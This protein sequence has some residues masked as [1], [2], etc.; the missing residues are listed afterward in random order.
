MN[1]FLT[2]L[3]ISLTLTRLE[4]INCPEFRHNTGWLSKEC[5][6]SSYCQYNQ[7][8]AFDSTGVPSTRNDISCGIPGSQAST[9]EATINAPT[10]PEEWKSRFPVSSY[11]FCPYSH[12]R[13][14][15]L[16]P[17]PGTCDTVGC[18]LVECRCNVDNCHAFMVDGGMEELHRG[19]RNLLL[20]EQIQNI[21]R[22][23]DEDWRYRG[24]SGGSRAWAGWGVVS[25]VTSV[26]LLWLQY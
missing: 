14:C 10:F 12:G 13:W 15:R 4:A 23:D 25:F 5:P 3:V 16:T 26:T 21:T 19:E 11:S 22:D 7:A 9:S 2:L 6:D 24:C 20:L 8:V 17:A 18:H 1:P